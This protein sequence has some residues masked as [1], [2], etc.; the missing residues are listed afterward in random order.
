MWFVELFK[1]FLSLFGINLVAYLSEWPI[2]GA[3][4][5]NVSSCDFIQWICS[6]HCYI[7]SSFF[8]EFNKCNH[9]VEVGL[10]GSF[11]HIHSEEDDYL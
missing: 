5:T 1:D 10:C 8:M 11:A 7:R 2:L 4:L 6:M 3:G 9:S